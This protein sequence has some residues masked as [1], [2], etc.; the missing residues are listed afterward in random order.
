M[1][2]PLVDDNCDRER[3]KIRKQSTLDCNWKLGKPIKENI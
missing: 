2:N 3:K 1:K